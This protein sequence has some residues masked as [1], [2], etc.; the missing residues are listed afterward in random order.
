MAVVS[1]DDPGLTISDATAQEADGSMEFTVTADANESGLRVDWSTASGTGS[2]AATSGADFTAGSG[3]LVFPAGTLSRT[4]TV[5]ILD[6]GVHEPDETFTVTLSNPTGAV[7]GRAAATGAIRDD[8][9]ETPPVVTVWTN[10]GNVEEGEPATFNFRRQAPG[11]A[12]STPNGFG[13][14][15]LTL[16]LTLTESGDFIEEALE[17]YAGVRVEHTPG[18]NT[19]TLTIPPTHLYFNVEFSTDDDQQ[20]EDNGSITLALAD[21]PGYT[22][23]AY[24]EATVN[25][26]DNDLGISIA[27]PKRHSE[28]ATE[29]SFTITLSKSSTQPVSVDVSTVD[30]VATSDDAV[31]ATSLGK[32]F[33]ARSETLTF[34]PGETEKVFTVSLVDDTFDE[35]EES[36]TVELSNPSDNVSLLDASATAE[37]SDNDMTMMVGVYREATKVNEDAEGQVEFRFELTPAQGSGTTASEKMATVRWTVTEGSATAGEDYEAVG[38]SERTQLQPGVL[39]KTVGVTLLDDELYED[40]YEQFT[41]DLKGA[42]NL[43]VDEDH[44]SIEVSL[45]DNETIQAD[46]AADSQNVAEGDDA[47]FTVTLTPFENAVPVTVKYEVVGSARPADYTAPSGKLTIPAGE[48]S[49]AVTIAILMDNLYDPGETL[50]IL[51][52]EATGGGRELT[53]LSTDDPPTVTILDAGALSASIVS[54]ASANEGDA[55]EFTVD[56]SIPTDMPVLVA[57]ETSDAEGQ[58]AADSKGVDYSKA[59]GTL[60]IS[61]GD[62]SGTFTVSTVEDNLV[63]GDETFNVVLKNAMKGADPQTST[64]VALG[65]ASA[66]ATI[67]DDDTAPTSITLTATPESVDE[68]AGETDLAVTATL[69]GPTRLVADVAVDLSLKGSVAAQEDGSQPASVTLTIPSGQASGTTTVTM[70]PA[71]D[72]IAGDGERVRIVG[73]ARGF[74]VTQAIVRITDDDDPPTGISLTISPASVTEGAGTTALAVTGTLTGGDRRSVETKIPLFVEGVSMSAEDEDGEATVAAT[75]N[76]DYT[77]ADVTLTIPAGESTGTAMLEFTATDDILAEGD[78]TAQVSGMSLEFEV[79][80]ALLTIEDDDREPDRIELSASPGGVAEH[81]GQVQIQVTATLAGGGARPAD[82]AV[83]L[84]VHDVSAV[85]GPDY[86]AGSGSALTIPA[87][88]VSGTASLSLTLV[89]DDIYEETETV[90]I[91]GSNEDPGLSVRGVRI[92]IAD[93]E[94]KPTEITLVLDRDTVSEGGGS[95]QLRVTAIVEGDSKR[96]ISTQVSLSFDVPTLGSS[97]GPSAAEFQTRASTTRFSPRSSTTAFLLL[98]R[99]SET[100]SSARSPAAATDYSVLGDTLTISAGESEGETVVVLSPID[101]SIV[102]GDESLEIRGFTP[103]LKVS[104]VLI[105]IT[106]DETPAVVLSKTSLTVEEEDASGET[107][108]VKLSHEPTET[109]TV[110]VSGQAGTDLTLTGLSATNTLTFT[111]TTWDTA[112]TVTVKAGEDNDAIDDT[113]ALSHTSSGGEYGGASADLAVTV[114]DNET[115][116]L[117]LSKSS[118]TVEEEDASGETYTV[119]LSHQPSETVTVTVSG[120]AGTD[121]TLTGLSGANTLTFTTTNWSEVQTVTVKAGEDN[122]AIDDTVALVHTATG[123]EYGGASADLAVTVNDNETVSLVLSKSSLTVEEEDASGE[124][125]TVTLSHQ[126]SETVTV[127]V[128]GQAG[129]D[130][131][132]TGLSGANTLTFTTTTWDTEQTVTVKAG[133]DNDA[134]DDVVTLVHAASG[135]EYGGAS[136]D[137]AVTVDDNETVSLVLS[138]TSLTVEEE[139]AG[140]ETYT[141]KLSHQP[142]ETVTV[143]VSGQSGTDLTLTGLSATNT[144][145]FTTTNWSEAQTVTVKAG[146]DE[147]AANDSVTLAHTS[148]G[149]E[150]AGKTADLPVTVDDNET[151]ALVLS[152]TSLTVEEE[153]TTGETYTVKLSHQPSVDVIVIVSGQAGTDLAL[154]GLSNADTL[155]FTTGTW[156]NAQTVTVTAGDD[157]DAIDDTVAL[158]HTSSGG[159]YA[160]KTADLAVTVDDNETVSIVLSKASLTV[161]EGDAGGETYTVKLSHQPST[162]VTVTVSGQAGTDLT[163][164]GLSASNTLTFTTTNWSEAQ[165]VTVKAGDD[166]DAANDSVTLAHTSSGG[167]YAGKTADLPVTVDD[168]ETAALVLS[169]TS[170]TVEEGDAG[171]ETYTV[172]LSHQPST[173]VTVTVSGQAGTDLTLTGLSA[174]NTLTF[175]TTN[176]SEAQTVTVKAGDDEDAANDSVTLAHTSSGGEYAGKTA[177]LPVTVDDDETAALVLSETSLTVEEEDAGGETYTVKLSHQPSE[178]VTVTISGHAG[179]DL[180]LGGLSGANTLTFTTTNWSEVQ[181]VTV[182]AG[183]D[184]DAANDAVTLVH[185]GAGGEYAGA[186]ADLAVTVDDNETVSLVLSKTSLT[187]EEGAT[188]GIEYTVKLSHQPSVDVTVTVSGQS[189]TDLTLTGLSNADTL[190]FT[191]ETWDNAQT[192]TV[193][194][195]EDNDA[196]DDTVALVHTAAGGEYAGKAANL[197]VAVDDNETVSIVLSKT[198]LTVEEEDASGETYTVKLSHQPSETVTVRVSGQSGTDLTLTGLSA[199]NTLAFTTTTWSEVQTVTVKAGEDNDAIDDTVALVHTAAGGEYAGVSADLAVTVDDNETVSIV[200]SRTSLTVEEGATTGVEYT[201]KLSHQPS[202]D[203]T[204]TVSGQAGTDLTLTGLSNADTLTFTTETWDNAQTVT[205]KAGEDNDAIDDTVALVHTA[206]GGEYG[207][208]SADLAVT[209]DDNETVSLVLS[210]SSLTVE[211]GDAS[212]ETYTVKLSHQPSETVTVTVSGQSGTD[213]TLTGLSATDTLAF[214]T[215]TWDNAQT[216][217][218]KAGEDNDAI[219]AAVTLVHTSSGGEY[220][221]KTADLPVKVDDNET[222]SIVLS[223]T[224]LTVEE[225]ATTGIEYT[226]KLSHQPSET[227]TVTISGHAGTDLTLGGL[228]NADMLTFTTTTWDDVQTV[229]V[230]AGQD[231]DAIDDAVTLAHA[232]TGGEYGGASADLAVTVDDNETVSLVLSKTSLTVEEGATTG[233]SYTVKLSHQP[234]VEVT[235]TVSGQSGTDLTLTGL[236]ATNTLTFTTGNWGTAQTVT[237]KAGE[238]EDAANDSATLAHTSAGGEYAGAAA[239]LPVTVTDDETPEVVLS[240]TS[241]TVEEGDTTG[242]SYTVKLSHQPSETVTVT[243]SGQSGTDLTLTGLSATDTLAFTTTTWNTAQ[244]VTVTAGDDTDAIDDTVA[245]SHTAAGGEYAGAAADLPVTVDDNETVSV[246]FGASEYSATEGGEDAVVEV[247]LGEALAVDVTVPL[248]TEGDGGATPDDW[249]GVPDAVTFSAGETSQTFTVVAFDDTVED[250]GEMVHLGFGVLPAGLSAGSPATAVVTLMNVEESMNSCGGNDIWCATVGLA[251]IASGPPSRWGS[252]SP[253]WNEVDKE[254]TYGGITYGVRGLYFVPDVRPSS[255]AESRFRFTFDAPRPPS[256]AHT[257]E[258]RLHVGSSIRLSFG[259]ATRVGDD[260]YVW[261]GAEFLPFRGG[262]DVTFRIEGIADPAKEYTPVTPNSP[263]TGPLTVSGRTQVGM[264]LTM[265][266]SNISDPD[267]MTGSTLH[268]YWVRIDGD[269]GGDIAGANGPTYTLQWN[270]EGATIRAKVTFTDDAGDR[271]QVSSAMTARVCA[272]DGE[273][274]PCPTSSEAQ[275]APIVNT[276]ATGRP[277]ISGTSSVGQTLTADTSGVADVNGMAGASFTYQWI[278]TDGNEDTDISDAIGSTYAVTDADVGY[279]IEVRVSFTDDEGYEETVTSPTVYVQTPQPLYGGLKDGP[280]SHDGSTA[281]TLEMHF[282]EEVSLEPAAVRDHVLDVTGGS[283]TG[284]RR[285]TPSSEAP[286]MR[287][288][289]TIT[290]SGNDAVSIVL[291]PT[292]DCTD[293]S[294]VCTA[295]DKMLSNRVTLSIAGPPRQPAQQEEEPQSPPPAPSNLQGTANGDGSITLTWDAPD[296]DSVTGYQILRRRPK[297][298]ELTL[299]VYVSDTGSAAT[300]YTDTGA[301]AGTLYAYRVKAINEAGAGEQ[302]DYVDVEP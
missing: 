153:D 154:T 114:N 33:E 98:A 272:V 279:E 6:D 30:G 179:T 199:T 232:A 14:S 284:A 99:S 215:E 178:T 3:T 108:T 95:Q 152:E 151:A 59:S 45:K 214:T 100:E 26:G 187:V 122:D 7:L 64:A 113:V 125:Y 255:A 162:D 177:D 252:G 85:A 39:S 183:Q 243:V 123:G 155:T 223:R 11:D 248:T 213:L 69:D 137:L 105:T 83:T 119:T 282:S 42:A 80:P 71:N 238:D 275:S 241:L 260:S 268:Y 262:M 74:D 143:T 48:S 171:G 297:E 10:Q 228:S 175:T 141:V 298:G 75:N 91:R 244:T 208:A 193:K 67:V 286:N 46:V 4:I 118:L 200:L 139:D 239:N 263:A 138:K 40:E 278:R 163:L 56:L 54:G 198:S 31:T 166:E 65:I 93:D 62:T 148:S 145:T 292:T 140:G 50:G 273:I 156:D 270:D 188:T 276:G 290:P 249:S 63:E 146:D 291:S 296:D 274:N 32:D 231:T 202:V 185:T 182:T 135:G 283:V 194:A 227:V 107:Y 170:L 103:G 157:T 116:S 204:V 124:T 2:N 203:V 167:E 287:W 38:R 254:F 210:K 1:D 68:D 168:D 289:I 129:T 240:K 267:G 160:G 211:E 52:T 205:V 134:I 60:T 235:V 132:L 86:T 41:F 147:D 173:D 102:E 142:S 27:G 53:L 161:E 117:V 158:V 257:A 82:T 106:D 294:A 189:G 90:A 58:Q 36:F 207:G 201:V 104:S 57:W 295:G 258:W 49:G 217:T 47:S 24:N 8:D 176:W 78:E 222:V 221:G 22:I 245:L 196:I 192:V 250:D 25:V 225:G 28:G 302:S 233:D 197:P 236:S 220:A 20:F 76:V 269:G 281:F 133:E 87:G 79:T 89:N 301:P 70:T 128:S 280:D 237:V 184:E 172:K 92:S 110:T 17:N 181:T 246:A 43:E 13:D 112:Q 121:L 37:I 266:I 216:V 234:S 219:D 72:E 144:L 66:V 293:A 61:A 277:A 191:T 131:T 285:L 226:V 180:T 209:V 5:E 259:D 218:V 165:T 256:E 21:G 88:Q 299:E 73:S 77:V 150:Y 18:S 115:V 195:G 265:D 130:L 94:E 159:E 12:E 23:G 149:G 84:S 229:T 261:K 169:E 19:A 186:T 111:T 35:S 164:T 44:Q 96:A 206:A 224:S 9:P 174:S 55:I 253:G 29:V 212:G 34:A 251:E 230:K 101:D 127:T 109:V 271:E 190:T 81:K 300:T 15:P 136:A 97:V 51:L 126:P 288:E 242:D 120:Q 247:Q 16:N 264:T